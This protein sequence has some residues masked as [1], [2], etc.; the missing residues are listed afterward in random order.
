MEED[1]RE[2][3]LDNY[4]DLFIN[5]SKTYNS[6]QIVYHIKHEDNIIPYSEYKELYAPICPIE[7]I[8]GIAIKENTIVVPTALIPAKYY[9]KTMTLLI[10]DGSLAFNKLNEIIEYGVY[11]RYI[12]DDNKPIKIKTEFVI[13]RNNN[14][15][16]G[17]NVYIPKQDNEGNIILTEILENNNSIIQSIP[18]IKFIEGG[19]VNLDLR[20]HGGINVLSLLDAIEDRNMRSYINQKDKDISEQMYNR[21]SDRLRLIYLDQSNKRAYKVAESHDGLIY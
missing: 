4:D 7:K 6:A 1:G 11:D 12:P 3:Y 17:V 21:F 13:L 9:I 10:K 14:K 20:V 19:K 5:Y 8:K 15:T 2:F 18:G 16:G